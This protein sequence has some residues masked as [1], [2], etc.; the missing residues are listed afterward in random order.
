VLSLSLLIIGC[1]ADSSRQLNQQSVKSHITANQ[2]AKPVIFILIDSLMGKPLQDAIQEGRVP[3][4][5]Y[6]LK[7][8][9]YFPQV[10][11]SFSRCS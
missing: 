5:Q 10:V 11:S 7:K 8:G 1:R 4:M 2:N 3:A 6:L 9:Q